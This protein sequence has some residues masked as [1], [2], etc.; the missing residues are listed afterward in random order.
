MGLNDYTYISSIYGVSIGNNTRIGE[1]VSIRDND[2]QFSRADVPIQ[3][4]GFMG[5]PIEIGEDVWI[6]R[7][8]FVGKG[9][10]IGKGAVVGANSVVTKNIPPYAVAVGVPAKVIKYRQTIDPTFIQ[11]SLPIAY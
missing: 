3:A 6:G 2:H 8:V 5:E 9:V 4:Q 11:D 1:F 10:C 7:G